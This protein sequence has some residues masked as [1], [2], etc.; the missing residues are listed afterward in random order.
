MK[1]SIYFTYIEY[2]SIINNEVLWNLVPK[3]LP[4]DKKRD[5]FDMRQPGGCILSFRAAQLRKIKFTT[6]RCYA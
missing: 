6:G 4:Y 1:S 3:F 5:C 2:F